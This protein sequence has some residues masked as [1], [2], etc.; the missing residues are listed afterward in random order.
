MILQLHGGKDDRYKITMSL[1]VLYCIYCIVLCSLCCV[2]LYCIYSVV[3]Y[4][5]YCIYCTYCI[6]L[7]LSYC[8]VLCCIVLYGIVASASLVYTMYSDEGVIYMQ[9]IHTAIE[10]RSQVM[11]MTDV[12]LLCSD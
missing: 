4:L 1:T 3:L 6:V 10:K 5:L 11:T 9:Y 7:Y 12:T 8:I 2:V